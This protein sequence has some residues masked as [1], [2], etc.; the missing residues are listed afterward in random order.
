MFSRRTKLSR[1][2]RLKRTL[3][4]GS[5]WWRASR[6]VVLRMVR[7]RAS[8]HRIALGCALGVFAAVTPLL[9][10][11]ML[12]AVV[13]ALALRAS[14]RAAVL[15]TFVG[16][17]VSWPVIWGATYAAGCALL[18]RQVL[19][20]A[21]DIERQM[22]TISEAIR[23]ATPERIDAAAVALLPVLT[24]MLTGSLLVGLITAVISYY[25]LRRAVAASKTRRRLA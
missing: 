22:S 9:G 12:L 16:N 8:P 25:I 4:P 19:L 7:L 21:G 10:I 15:G 3:W 5:G 17:P 24:P 13:L 11:Q 23:E 6:Y 1:T 14:V 2:E 18:G 20:P